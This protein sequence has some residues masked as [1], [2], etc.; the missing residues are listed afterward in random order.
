MSLASRTISLMLLALLLSG[1]ARSQHTCVMASATASETGEH[2]H[3]G[4][5]DEPTTDSSPEDSCRM[6]VACGLS[7]SMRH[8]SFTTLTSWR[9]Q[10]KEREPSITYFPPA[11]PHETP[12]PRV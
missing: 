11:L 6:F 12:P 10:S 2:Q 8:A 9:Y 1:A 7:L 3:H 5:G 4:H